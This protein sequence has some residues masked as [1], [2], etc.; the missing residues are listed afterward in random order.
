VR[1][2]RFASTSIRRRIVTLTTLVTTPVTTL[3]TTSL[4]TL[5]VADN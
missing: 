5:F 2:G 4:A 1:V 3:V